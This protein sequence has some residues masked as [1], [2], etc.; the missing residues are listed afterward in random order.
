MRLNKIKKALCYVLSSAMVI[1]TLYVST[2]ADAAKKAKLGTKRI[3][4]NVKRSKTIVI[5]NKSSK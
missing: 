4:V 1:G 5:K 2:P 3:N